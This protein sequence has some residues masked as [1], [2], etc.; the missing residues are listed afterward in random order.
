MKIWESEKPNALRI[1]TK[2]DPKIPER[3]APEPK[4]PT[5]LLG[6]PLQ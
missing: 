5:K 6:N 1:N 2:P 3:P 4:Y